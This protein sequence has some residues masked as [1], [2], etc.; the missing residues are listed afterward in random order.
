[1]FVNNV[2]QVRVEQIEEPKTLQQLRD[3]VRQM[4]ASGQPKADI[5]LYRGQKQ[6]GS[7]VEFLKKYYSRY[8][9]F[10]EQHTL[11]LHDLRV[12]DTPLARALN[13]VCNGGGEPMPLGTKPD[14]TKALISG[15]FTDGEETEKRVKMAQ[16]R[17]KKSFF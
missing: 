9:L 12:I 5:P 1:M 13:T 16:R 4:V 15:L 8:L 10:G 3:E 14:L 17:Q 7:P 6:N 2:T 11:F